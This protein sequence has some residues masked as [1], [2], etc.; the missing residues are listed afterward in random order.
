MKNDEEF[1]CIEC[2]LK[3]KGKEM[4]Q[5]YYLVCKECAK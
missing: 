3:K 2:G 4:S 1:E 5:H